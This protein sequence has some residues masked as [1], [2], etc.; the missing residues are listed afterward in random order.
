MEDHPIVLAER[1][2]N[3]Y[4]YPE[5]Q[6]ILYPNG[7]ISCGDKLLKNNT[8]LRYFRR[9]HEFI[10]E[11]L[12]KKQFFF[13]ISNFRLKDLGDIISEMQH[14]NSKSISINKLIDIYSYQ[15]QIVAIRGHMISKL[16]HVE[17][18]RWW[19]KYRKLL[20]TDYTRAREFHNEFQKKNKIVN[21]IINGRRDRD[22]KR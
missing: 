20:E 19:R 18:I 3:P 15:N 4:L 2:L 14:G 16:V 7:D 6:I 17:R 1:S 21:D 5:E 11:Y 12:L 22:W 13:N 10:A 8:R 9:Q